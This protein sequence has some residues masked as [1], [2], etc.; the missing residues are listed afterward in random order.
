MEWTKMEESQLDHSQ[1]QRIKSTNAFRIHLQVTKKDKNLEL[2]LKNK[3][4]QFSMIKLWKTQSQM[5]ILVFMV[6]KVLII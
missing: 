3:I 1:F 2:K 5:L 4:S 6:G